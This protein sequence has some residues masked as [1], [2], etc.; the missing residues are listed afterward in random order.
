MYSVKPSDC[1]NLRARGR[2]TRQELAC[3]QN[4]QARQLKASLDDKVIAFSDGVEE[5]V[6]IERSTSNALVYI[7]NCRSFQDAERYELGLKTA[8]YNPNRYGNC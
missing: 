8:G 5:V 2:I 6:R 3:I 4:M 7:G 1:I